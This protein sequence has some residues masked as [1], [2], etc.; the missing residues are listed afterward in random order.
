MTQLLV[1]KSVCVFFILYGSSAEKACSNSQTRFLQ[2]GMLAHKGDSPKRGNKSVFKYIGKGYSIHHH[3]NTA[4][5]RKYTSRWSNSNVRGCIAWPFQIWSVCGQLL[6][7]QH[8][9]SAL[10]TYSDFK[11]KVKYCDFS[12]LVKFRV[13]LEFV[14]CGLGKISHFSRLHKVSIFWTLPKFA[15]YL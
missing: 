8:L 2:T 12:N 15:L 3:V 13:F 14:I 1:L 6:K 11:K 9:L 5:R 7:C 10:W 4:W